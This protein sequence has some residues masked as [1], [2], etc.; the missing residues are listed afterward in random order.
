[1]TKMNPEIKTKWLAALREPDRKQAIGELE[2]S[3]GQCCLGVLCEIAANE[4]I[5]DRVVKERILPGDT[6]WYAVYD[7]NATAL[8]PASVMEWAG[9]EDKSAMLNER[10]E[11]EEG[12]RFDN[13]TGLNDNGSSFAEIADVIERQF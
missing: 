6:T 9:I 7:E 12:Y 4:G 5:V 3:S 10:V 11:N 8:L 1:M 13:L 2:N